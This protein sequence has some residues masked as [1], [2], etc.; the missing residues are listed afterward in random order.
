MLHSVLVW[1]QRG[2]TGPGYRRI[3]HVKPPEVKR[4][5]AWFA[6]SR[7][8]FFL[9]SRERGAAATAVGGV[10]ILEL[11]AASH[12]TASDEVEG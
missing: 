7:P 6:P 10:G 11:E 8:V 4:E 5:E 1:M 3:S 9:L 2:S 12:Q